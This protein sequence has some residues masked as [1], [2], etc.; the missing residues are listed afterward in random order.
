MDMK[1]Y[2]LEYAERGWAVFPVHTPKPDGSCSCHRQN[3]DRIGKHPRISSGRNGASSDADT[4]NRWWTTWPDANIGIATGKESGFIVLDVDDGGEDSLTGKPLPDTVEQITGSGGRHLLYNRPETNTQ[5]YKTRVK[6]LP[7][8]DSRADGGYI[9]APPSLHKSGHRYGWE[10]SSDPMEGVELADPPAWFIEAIADTAIEDSATAAPQWNPD[11]ELPENTLEMLTYIPAEDYDTWRDVGMAIHYTDPADGL[12]VWDWWSGTASNYSSDAVRREWR[13]FSRRGHQVANPVTMD[14]VARLAEQHGWTDPAIEHGSQV[15][16]K[17]MESHQR[18]VTDQLTKWTTRPK[19][20]SAPEMLP[21]SGLIRD[22]CD[23][24]LATSIR[25]QPRLAV[26]ASVSLVAALAGRKYR[27]ETG[28]MS[29]L[30]IAALAQSGH[31]KDHARKVINKLVTASGADDFLGGD[32]IASGQ[33]V[34]SALVRHP[35]KLFMIDEFGKFLGA[36]TG[37]KAAPHQRDIITKLMVLYSSAGSVYRG[38]EYADQKERP[39]EDIVNPNACVYGTSVAENFWG[40]MSSSEGGDGTMSRLIVIESNP[41][42]PK[43]QRPNMAQA[44]PAVIDAIRDLANHTPGSGNLAGKAGSGLDELAQTVPMTNAVFDAWEALDDDMTEN[45]KDGISA[46]I[47]SRVAEN[48]AKLAMVYAVSMDHHSPVI[49]EDAFL[50]GREIALWSANTLMHNIGRN[51]ADN[52]QEASHKRVL[53]MI[54]DAGTIK[55]RDLMRRCKFL[56]KREL[57][58]I[59]ALSLETGE[60]RV[61]NQK[62]KTGPAATVYVSVDSGGEHGT[63]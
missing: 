59:V 7:G 44:D 21:P 17:L 55:R 23:H 13:N 32:A 57:D 6:F 28:L 39:R 53:N 51:V 4:I 16:A 30:Y 11:G 61:E 47:Y 25:P 62:S 9:V 50:W 26:A 42:R 33:A 8:L 60:I 45:M 5:R 38:T 3:C 49:D 18:K 27:T 31:G 56:K 48:A 34:I 41:E 63:E 24:I 2:A 36:L 10:G 14:T 58:E 54:H 43:R 19:S 15:A 29:N 20:I 35:S 37:Q 12:E 52:Q 1:K 22:L 40:A 46:S